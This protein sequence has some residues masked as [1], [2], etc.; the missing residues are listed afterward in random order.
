MEAFFLPADRGARLCVH[1]APL[2]PRGVGLVALPAF[3]EEMNKS[4]HVVA[5]A[6][7]L[8][9]DATTF[10]LW[11]ALL[12]GARLQIILVCVADKRNLV[13]VAVASGK[14]RQ[15]IELQQRFGLR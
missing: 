6:A 10:E 7:P 2:T 14:V 15:R 8:A 9:F 11:P 3:A 12:N 5:Q 4:R 13:V 1:H